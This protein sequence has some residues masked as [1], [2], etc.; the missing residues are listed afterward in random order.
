MNL[1]LLKTQEDRIKYFDQFN[2]K[3]QNTILPENLDGTSKVIS[4]GFKNFHEVSINWTINNVCQLDCKYC[5]AKEM[6]KVPK[7]YNIKKALINLKLVRVPFNICLLGG[8]PTL[9]EDIFQIIKTL[10]SYKFC[11]DI[12]LTTN[13][14]KD[15]GFWKQF[16][17]KEFS[18]KLNIDASYHPQYDVN[19]IDKIL[20]LHKLKYINLHCNINIFPENKYFE[21]TK[22]IIKI[23]KDNNIPF[24]LND[25]H[26]TPDF[27]IQYKDQNYL[28]FLKI[29]N[30]DEV[31]YLYE[32][33]Y[34]KQAYTLSEIN[35][36][37]LN[38]FKGFKCTAQDLVI[39]ESGDIENMCTGKKIHIYT[40][41][42]RDEMITCPRDICSCNTMLR[43]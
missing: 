21:K 42:I 30:K 1:E 16:N 3:I 28:N 17:I 26:E 23:V 38:H 27:K 24:S 19:Y 29:Y 33:N 9:H 37:K 2:P 7:D 11:H 32:I 31:K 36:S 41:K 13:L 6:M 40:E 22:N 14:F 43:F 10:T 25:I 20:E 35:N 34:T 8:E 5:Y 4:Q 18:E 12:D 39:N 15:I